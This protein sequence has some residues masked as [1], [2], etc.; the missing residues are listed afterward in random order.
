MEELSRVGHAIPPTPIDRTSTCLSRFIDRPARS[1]EIFAGS[2]GTE[3]LDRKLR[4]D[5]Y[6]YVCLRR[7]AVEH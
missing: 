4:A 5:T 6:L 2:C 3:G 7:L 1:E